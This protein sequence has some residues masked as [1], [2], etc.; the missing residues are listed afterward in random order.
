MP[1]LL[2]VVDGSRS[3]PGVVALKTVN[4]QIQPGT[5]HA[6][7]GENGAGKSTLIKALSGAQSLSSGQILWN[8]QEVHLRPDLALELGIATVF[9]E[10]MLVPQLTAAQNILLG[11]EQMVTR[12]GLMQRAEI[13]RRASQALSALQLN[14]ELD[15]PVQF[16]S[17]ANRQL[18]EIARAVDREIKLLILDEPTSSLS[19]VEIERMLDLIR[20]IRKKGVSVLF[21]SHKLPEVLA[22]ADRVTVLRD[23]EVVADLPAAGLTEEQL[24]KLMVGREL[25]EQYPYVAVPAGRTVLDV[26]GL[27][28]FTGRF[29]DIDLQV[30]AGEVVG[31]TGLIGSGRSALMRAIFGIDRYQKGTI[32]VGEERLPV[33]NPAESL[34]RGLVLLPENRK[35]EGL[36][37]AL[38]VAENIAMTKLKQL[39]VPF[40]WKS[41]LKVGQFAKDLIQ[42]YRVKTASPWTAVG[43]LSGG[44]QQKVII[45]RA[46]SIQP[47]CV[48]FDEPTRGIDV[49]AKY[50][51]YR[52]INQL[53]ES[54]IAVLM[55]S[56]ELNEVMGLSDRLLVMRRGRIAGVFERPQFTAEA[57]GQTA[58]GVKEATL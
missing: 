31:I 5:V 29:S 33:G 38:S 19:G 36:W 51:I 2:E 8:G 6:L 13:R 20:R 42:R 11:R 7:I 34:H 49:G 56:S 23:G 15:T 26:R 22:I 50:E 25:E 35:D 48:L 47:R 45:G 10:L 55:V 37:L 53:K 1:P 21:V 52:I 58:L 16:L 40:G 44:N 24:V 32:Q 27:S 12:G 43:Q 28:G 54:G 9:Q 17:L 46:L 57:I 18:V 14:V 30:R 39:S 3:F 41:N 4:L